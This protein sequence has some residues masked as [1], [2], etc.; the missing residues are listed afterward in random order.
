MEDNISNPQIMDRQRKPTSIEERKR[1]LV[2]FQH[3]QILSV[4]FA[5]A[6]QFT[7]FRVFVDFWDSETDDLREVNREVDGQLRKVRKRSQES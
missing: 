3:S 5:F 1:I 7:Y 6:S 2:S 4:Q